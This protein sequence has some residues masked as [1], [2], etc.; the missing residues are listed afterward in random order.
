LEDNLKRLGVTCAHCFVANSAKISDPINGLT[1]RQFIANEGNGALLN[2]CFDF[3]LLDPPCTGFGQRPDFGAETDIDFVEHASFQFHLLE[4]AITLLKTGGS[5]VYST[6]SMSLW[7][8]ED[9]V[10]R[11]LRKYPELILEPI[12]SPLGSPCLPL[13]SLN[14]YQRNC[15]RRFWP[16]EDNSIG[17]FICKFKKLE[18][19]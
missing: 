10:N 19:I 7:E 13:E 15:M 8:N 4:T 9:V 3:I 5:L 1:P 12:G 14:D 17:F 16:N 11:I 6:C 2:D 18:S